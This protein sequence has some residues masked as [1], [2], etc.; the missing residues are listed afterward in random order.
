MNLKQLDLSLLIIFDTLLKERN[1]SAA[2]NKLATSQPTI[3]Y[4][5]KKLRYALED[6]LFIRSGGEMVPTP[7]ALELE[8]PIQKLIE[9]LDTEVL[10]KESFDPA[11]FKKTF[12]INT[13]DIGEI[14]FIPPLLNRLQ[15]LAPHVQIECVCLESR[16]LIKAMGA[17]EVDLAI[18]YLPDIGG[19]NLYVQGLFEHP[20]VCL[21]RE[22]HPLIGAHPLTLSAY[23]NARHIA[24]VGEG[25]SQKK[26]EAMIEY[27]GISR[28]IAFRSQHFMNIPFIVRDSDLIATVPKVIAFAHQHFPGIKAYP[29]PFDLPAVPVK[30]YWHQ[31]HHKTPAQIWFRHMVAELFLDQDPTTDVDLLS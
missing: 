19:T 22:D 5:L 24:L 30:Q 9:I 10:G 20:F 23:T 12:V 21:A 1:V 8:S 3:S 18:G 14:F 17:G 27:A 16:T 26:F 2:A 28:Q 15:K 6:E 31:R 29:P 7:R 25:H 11:T 4:A 13:T